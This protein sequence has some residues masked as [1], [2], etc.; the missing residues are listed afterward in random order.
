LSKSCSDPTYET[1]RIGFAK[2]LVAT[3]DRVFTFATAEGRIADIMR[4]RIVPV[5]FACPPT[6]RHTRA[7]AREPVCSL[8]TTYGNNPADERAA[9]RL[10]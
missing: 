9:R 6:P 1:E 2:R 8:C 7:H 10:R 4:T 5:I 3:T